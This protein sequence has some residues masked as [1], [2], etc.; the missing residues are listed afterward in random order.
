M[1]EVQEATKAIIPHSDHARLQLMSDAIAKLRRLI[2]ANLDLSILNDEIT[3]LAIS[4]LVDLFASNGDRVSQGTLKTFPEL[5]RT[6]EPGAI[7][8]AGHSMKHAD[9]EKLLGSIQLILNDCPSIVEAVLASSQPSA[10]RKKTHSLSLVQHERNSYPRLFT[11]DFILKTSNRTRF[12]G[13]QL[14]AI[15]DPF[16]PGREA[17]RAELELVFQRLPREARRKL[18]NRIR[19]IGNG[20]LHPE[21]A[22]AEL[23][24]FRYLCEF[25]EVEYEPWIGGKTPDFLVKTDTGDFYCE[26]FTTCD[27]PQKA[28]RDRRFVEFLSRLDSLQSDFALSVRVDHFPADLP[29]RSLVIAISDWLRTLPTVVGKE[30]VLSLRDIGVPGEV[31]AIFKNG[32]PMPHGNVF[33]WYIKDH[34]TRAIEMRLLKNMNHKGSKYATLNTGGVPFV[35]ATSTPENHTLD[36]LEWLSR[37]YGASDLKFRRDIRY[38]ACQPGLRGFFHNPRFA[39]ISA[40]LVKRDSWIGGRLREESVLFENPLA[41][42]PLPADV[43]AQF[44]RWFVAKPNELDRAIV[45]FRDIPMARND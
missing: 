30:F 32:I 31:K 20:H 35:L 33:Q 14:G 40:L 7:L 15:C 3:L 12:E 18:N 11:E 39:F 26:V 4:K 34:K 10:P 6:R 17:Q 43:L 44:P 9:C 25:G 27:S 1:F 45:A 42:V 2:G 16:D 21:S 23:C 5:S 8:G 37:L 19:C 29:H 24:F 22:L 41:K 36:Q 13:S 28:Q 38:L